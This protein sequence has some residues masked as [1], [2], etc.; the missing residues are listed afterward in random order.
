MDIEPKLSLLAIINKADTEILHKIVTE[1][2][3]DDIQSMLQPWETMDKNED[4]TTETPDLLSSVVDLLNVNIDPTTEPPDLLSSVVDLLN[5]NTEPTDAS[6]KDAVI[7]LVDGI[8]NIIYAMATATDV[9][10]VKSKYDP[11][12]SL[13][14][15]N[16]K[17]GKKSKR[18]R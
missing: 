7:V 17:G 4:P 13:N 18:I 12:K 6:T 9:T 15:E 5:V 14:T 16:P 2:E 8:D 11:M 1:T 3:K 10:K